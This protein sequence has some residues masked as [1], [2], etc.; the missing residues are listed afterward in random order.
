MNHTVF[1]GPSPGPRTRQAILRALLPTHKGFL[2][3]DKQNL[4]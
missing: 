4:W 1:F 3:M 2:L